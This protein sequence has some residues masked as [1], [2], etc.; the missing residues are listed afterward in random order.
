MIRALYISFYPSI[1]S[2]LISKDVFITASSFIISFMICANFAPKSSKM[3]RL[4]IL[5]GSLIT[6]VAAFFVLQEKFVLFCFLI[7]FVSIIIYRSFNEISTL[8]SGA[9]SE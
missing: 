5:V 7:S 3:I 4:I 2:A 9:L 6:I 1:V 8:S